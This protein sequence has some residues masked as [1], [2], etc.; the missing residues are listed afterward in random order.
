[1]TSNEWTVEYYVEDSGAVPV[2][3]FLKALEQ[4]A[5]VR[6]LWSLEQLRHVIF[7]RANRSPVTGQARFGS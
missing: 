7:W 2:R 3:E 6:S 1:M 4:Q 5:Y